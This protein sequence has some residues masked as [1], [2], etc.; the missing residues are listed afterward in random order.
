MRSRSAASGSPRELLF[1]GSFI[2]V[3]RNVT[4]PGRAK[5]LYDTEIGPAPSRLLTRLGAEPIAESTSPEKLPIAESTSPEKLPIS[6]PTSPERL[7]IPERTFPETLAF[8]LFV[9]DLDWI[10]IPDGSPPCDEDKVRALAESYRITR[11]RAP[12]AV[13]ELAPRAIPGK[14]LP[15]WRFSLLSD[16]HRL[17][18]LKR[19]GITRAECLVIK[20]NE[21]DERLWKLAELIHQPQAKVLDRA[22]AVMEWVRYVREKGAQVAHPRGGRQ[23]HDKGI[24]ATQRVFGVTRRDLGRFARIASICPEAQEEIRRANLDDTQRAL[25]E[26]ANEPPEKQVEKARELKERYSKPRWKRAT[27]ADRKRDA[28]G[29][30]R[31]VPKTGP[32]SPEPPEQESDQAEQE[33]IESPNTPPAESSN[34]PIGADEKFEALKARWNK[35]MVDGWEDAPEETHIRFITEVQGYSVLVTKKTGKSHD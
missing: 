20:G 23:P 15:E 6:E 9:L 8:E 30:H 2:V 14:K 29:R 1:I 5:Q 33:V 4:S 22:H 26:I 21:A 10:I 18:A 16:P 11:V 31:E 19:L 25:L 35:Y 12:L 3:P 7:M 17:E 13:R 28:S 32:L 34:D 24:T 27:S